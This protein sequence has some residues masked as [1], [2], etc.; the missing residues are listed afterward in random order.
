MSDNTTTNE[1]FTEAPKKR[2]NGLPWWG[3][4]AIIVLPLIGLFSLPMIF[5]EPPEQSRYAKQNKNSIKVNPKNNPQ[6][7]VKPKTNV[8]NIN[9]NNTTKSNVNASQ[10][11]P[12]S[13]NNLNNRPA[14]S[15]NKPNLNQNNKKPAT[16]PKTNN[17][18]G[19]TIP[20]KNQGGNNSQNN[21]NNAANKNMN[22]G[23]KKP[24]PKPAQQSNIKKQ[25]TS[26]LNQTKNTNPANVTKPAVEQQ[27]KPRQPAN[28]Q[29]VESKY[30]GS[31]SKVDIAAQTNTTE[32]INFG[33]VT[34]ND[35]TLRPASYS[36]FIKISNIL[37]DN[38]S[39]KITIRTHNEDFKN[40]TQNQT[41]KQKSKVRADLLKK[42]L[43][44]SGVQAN[45]IKV[46]LVG[47]TEPLIKEDPSHFRNKRVSVK[48]N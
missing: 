8:A 37:I 11:R 9:R 30:R 31:A 46:E 44:D 24:L 25:P 19:K 4:T 35:K 22:T 34:D 2:K 38:P 36:N 41:A 47:H 28:P 13:N 29:N 18:P 26:N 12:A 5:G 40:S 15:N 14:T 45:R 10:Q 23:T 43:V 6:K 48:I 3:W 17:A 39:A 42:V 32:I 21:L 27:T 1:E 20:Q 7:T 16:Q 33:T